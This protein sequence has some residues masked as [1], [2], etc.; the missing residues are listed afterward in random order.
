MNER[1]QF[2]FVCEVHR[3]CKFALLAK[4]DLSVIVKQE[5]PDLDRIWMSVQTVLIAVGNISKLL[6]PTNPEYEDRGAELRALLRVDKESVL[7]SRKFRNHF[8]HFDERLE[9]WAAEERTL[10]FD[11]N[12]GPIGMFGN[13]DPRNFV[14]HFDPD[15]RILVF[16]DERYELGPVL[17]AASDLWAR[18][19]SEYRKLV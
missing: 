14:R 19:E 8:E 2:A 5:R 4:E 15:N 10:Q 11:C 1:T 3:Q 13:V 16:G 6:W 18:A 7:S 9:A 12:V 17:D